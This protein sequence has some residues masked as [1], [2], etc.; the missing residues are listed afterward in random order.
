[1][2]ALRI[3]LVD[4]QQLFVQSMKVVIETSQLEVEKVYVA[5]DGGE[6]FETLERHP[7]DVVL[8]D[9]HMPGIDGIE[10]LRRIRSTQP[11]TKVIMLSAFGY[12][13]YV[14]A[15]MDAGAR[16]YLLKDA[17]PELVIG[18][19]EQAMQ[20]GVVMSDEILK[21]VARPGLTERV[22]ERAPPTWLSHLSEKERKILYLISL[23]HDNEEI[24]GEMNMA[25]QTI[26]N[27]VSSIY[28]KLGIKNRFKAMR[29]A[30][31]AQISNYVVDL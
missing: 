11:Q 15:A 9:V 29:M 14:R 16:G 19:I 18:A 17:M 30:I 10:A 13:E 31:E 28:K 23:G 21:A 20:G 4:D 12:D 25:Y 3:L 7:V 24:A 27:Y 6:A 5:H 26:R 2:K 1:M 22:D 8:L